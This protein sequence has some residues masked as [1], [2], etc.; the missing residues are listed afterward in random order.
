MTLDSTSLAARVA[1]I[2]TLSRHLAYAQVDPELYVQQT[3]PNFAAMLRLSPDVVQQQPITQW[4][5]TLQ[6]A[7]PNLKKLLQGERTH[8]RLD[9]GDQNNNQLSPA[10][11]HYI[12]HFYPLDEGNPQAGLLLIFENRSQMQVMLA[13]DQ[14]E[15]L[16][17][18]QQ[19]AQ[20]NAELHRVNQ[21]KSLFV[22][23][24]AH[25]LRTP[26][27][28]IFGFADM[29]LEDLQL[30]DE[31]KREI[32]AVIRAQS[33]RLSRLI[34]DLLDIERIEQGQLIL[35][36]TEC[37][38]NGITYEVLESLKP[39]YESRHLLME[40][41][42]P[43]PP[44]QL[45]G[46]AARIWQILYNLINNAI[47]Y[48]SEKGL[49]K[50]EIYPEQD[51]VILK[52]TDSGRGMTAEQLERLFDL[53]YR[54]VEAKASRVLGSGLGL[55]IVKTMVEAHNG[56]VKVASELGKGT[57]FTVRLPLNLI[58]ARGG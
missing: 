49:V 4:L 12:L 29:L 16:L 5:P 20:A 18:Q 37:D 39:L 34:A 52:V 9:Y 55:Y 48:T 21:I 13:P 41:D 36:P 19:L 26:L 15:L 43:E 8:F 44:L 6:A 10:T 54:T 27:T 3:S 45:C 57:M 30:E 28:T 42:L 7:V 31:V 56:E 53:Y 22:S 51:E 32:L 50:I 24:A 23:M 11:T 2:F 1:E 38:L 40:I 14:S 25:D 33:E 46:D 58:E 47:K 17:T 35:K